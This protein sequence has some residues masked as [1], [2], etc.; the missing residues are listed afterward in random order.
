MKLREE[1]EEELTIIL[2]V[3][4]I[5]EKIWNSYNFTNRGKL[6]QIL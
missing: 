4:A 2:I 6:G 5:L 3:V 1:E